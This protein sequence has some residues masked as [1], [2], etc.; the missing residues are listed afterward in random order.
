MVNRK[1]KAHKHTHTH[2]HTHTTHMI[3]VTESDNVASRSNIP[4]YR[5]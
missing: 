2:T 4:T 5:S 3:L 1:G